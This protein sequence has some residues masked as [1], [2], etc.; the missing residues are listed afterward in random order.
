MQR[1][2]CNS[3]TFGRHSSIVVRC[4]VFLFHN[5]CTTFHHLYNFAVIINH[6]PITDFFLSPM[7]S[8]SFIDFK[9]VFKLS[10]IASKEG[11][12][13]GIFGIKVLS[14]GLCGKYCDFK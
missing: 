14:S 4:I 1:L 10:V 2:P 13:H 5:F 7:L 12:S 3:S 8:C 9:K 6:P 11:S